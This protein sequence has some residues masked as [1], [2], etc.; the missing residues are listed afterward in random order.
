MTATAL[1]AAASPKTR[2]A[3]EED[4]ER[5]SNDAT[6]AADRAARAERVRALQAE[7]EMLQTVSRKKIN[8]TMNGFCYWRYSTHYPGI[9]SV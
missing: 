6:L 3:L 9:R 2:F 7:P 4:S 5:A 1:E 8:S